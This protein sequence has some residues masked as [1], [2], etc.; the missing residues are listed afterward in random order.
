MLLLL[1]NPRPRLCCCQ[2]TNKF[3][4][5]GDFLPYVMYHNRKNIRFK[6]SDSQRK[7]QVEPRKTKPKTN[8]RHMITDRVIIEF[9]ALFSVVQLKWEKAI[10]VIGFTIRLESDV[11]LWLCPPWLNMRFSLALTFCEL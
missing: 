9:E 4:S 3:S 11:C 6:D 7:P 8:I 5:H 10:T 2:K 1:P